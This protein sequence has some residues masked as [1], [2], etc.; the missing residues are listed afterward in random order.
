M[1]L[2]RAIDGYCERLGPGLW[3]EPLNA[4]SN[5]AF[6]LAALVMWRRCRRPGGKSK[7]STRLLCLLLALIGIGSGVF[8]TFAQGWAALADVVPIGMFILTYLFAVNRDVLGLSSGMALGATAFFLPYAGVSG[9]LFARLPWLGASA[10]YAPVPL[11]I[12]I[13]AV[14]LWRRC[15]RLARGFG[16][17][18]TLLLLSLTARTLDLPLCGLWPPGTH[19]Y[20]HLLN[21]GMLAWMIETYRCHLAEVRKT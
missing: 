7:G 17:G 19:V 8:H 15:P 16:L 13:Y 3:A 1:D 21:A 11:L 5:L 18:A 9:A 10:G 12:L 14:V 4:L 20:W 2:T 6:L